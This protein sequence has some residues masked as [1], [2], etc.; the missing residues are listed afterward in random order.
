MRRFLSALIWIGAS[1]SFA[2]GVSAQP[3]SGASAG[4]GSISG[5]VVNAT[6][7]SPLRRARVD[8]QVFDDR[9]LTASAP[10]DA[11]GRFTIHNLPAGKFVLQAWKRD[12]AQLP[13]GATTPDGAGEVV[14]LKAGEQRDGISFRLPPLAV[15]SGVVFTAD[16]DPLLGANVEVGQRTIFRGKPSV[17]RVRAGM[18]DDRGRF[19]IFDLLAGSY[20]ISAD[21]QPGMGRPVM[22]FGGQPTPEGAPELE[23]TYRKT[24]YGGS[25]T[26]TGASTVT[27]SGTQP[28]E[29]IELRLP[30]VRMARVTGDVTAPI[31]IENNQPNVRL[32]ASG[33][34]AVPI[35]LFIGVN[36]T[37]HFESMP[38]R[39]GT[40]TLRCTLDVEGKTYAA[41]QPVDLTGGDIEGLALKLRPAV[42]ITGVAD[43]DGRPAAGLKVQLVSP[44]NGNGPA[45][46]RGRFNR[47]RFDAEEAEVAQDGKF[48][49]KNVTPGVWDINVQPV[50]KG[51][52]L[53]AML[54]GTADVLRGEMTIGTETP[55]PMRISVSSKAGEVSGKIEGAHKGVVLLAP[56]GAS[57]DVMSFYER[58]TADDEG[59]F[60]V[61]GITPG[62]YKLYAFTRLRR[63]AWSDPNFLTP[64]HERGVAVEIKEGDK[65]TVDIPQLIDIAPTAADQLESQPREPQ[66]TFV[67]AGGPPPPPAPPPPAPGVSQ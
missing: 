61:R 28:A 27:V 66:A 35:S 44:D 47:G 38:V 51:G 30:V 33:D 58:V 41:V 64:F 32:T 40:Y 16:G 5:T 3:A 54:L 9:T 12:F 1:L 24:Y 20:V 31:S 39:E 50:P 48:I 65:Q 23:V 15:I 22:V 34:D 19:R 52:Y 17:Q 25:P 46:N 14:T 56:D 43:L 37:G 13:F 2:S 57:A 62:S 67:Q 63:Q 11:A 59:R 18:T 26:A 29:G 42:D 10:T 60:V 6:T 4:T 21:V 8:L 36:P 49:L 55:P 7:G 45:F 53:K